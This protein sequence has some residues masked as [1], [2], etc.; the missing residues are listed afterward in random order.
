MIGQT[1]DSGMGL[2]ED[3]DGVVSG[4]VCLCG[5]RWQDHRRRLD[6]EYDGRVMAVLM[7]VAPERWAAAHSQPCLECGCPDYREDEHA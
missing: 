7:V 6:G 1:E 4:M 2:Q 5:D 3:F